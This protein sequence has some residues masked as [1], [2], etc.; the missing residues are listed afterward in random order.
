[1][2]TPYVA[3]S[4]PLTRGAFLQCAGAELAHPVLAAT[5]RQPVLNAESFRP[6]VDFFNRIDRE[7]VVNAIPNGSVWDWMKAN[8][9]RFACPDRDAEQIYY[10]RWW[11]FRKHIRET[12]LGFIITEF[13]KKVSHASEFNA[14][15]CALGHHVA[16][17]RW[18]HDRRY[19]E[20]DV[21]FWL[22][23]GEN[24]GLRRNFHQ[25]SG[26]AAASLYDRWL[27]D[28]DHDALTGY[29]DALL[30]DY[31]AWESER[32]TD[33]GLFWQRDVSDG[34]EE[35]ISGG[36]HV[37][38]LRPSINSYMY[39][40]ARAIAAIAGMAGKKAV[41]GEY[42]DK[43]ARIKE[44]VQR[45][46]WNP[47]LLFFDTIQ[48]SGEFAGVRENI[49]YTPW[50]FDLPSD[51]SG[52]EVAWRQLMDE[53]GFH[54]PFGPTT[55]ERRHP[56]FSIEYKTGDD[57]SWNGPSWPFATTITL[58]ALANTL[59]GYHQ[60]AT[61]KASWMETFQ[62]YTRSQHRRREDGSVIPWIDEN[63]DPLT[64]VWLARE[65]KSRKSGFYER[66]EFY[67]HSGYCDLVITGLAGLRPRA[68]NIVEVNPMIGEGEWEWFCLD[69]VPYHGRTLT[70]VW[71]QTGRKFGRG[72]GLTVFADGKRIAHAAG[73]GRVT[74]RL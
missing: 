5:E 49:G 55:S 42:L 12:P 29:L 37:R 34:M 18:L 25:F 65:R 45:K 60:S 17:G 3:G 24:G 9:P 6:Y 50:Y 16:E 7:E 62:I 35:S 57:C 36:R 39:G 74:G 19:V 73:L 53:G 31:G 20:Q 21:H 71:D 67:N 40:N 47:G 72:R 69:H 23:T 8:V 2:K 51:R 68:D 33:S 58:R 66:G 28:G 11:T 32:L 38:N 41:A 30:A 52:Y 4:I 26:W 56:K 63:L 44:R 59:N 43:A 64:G 48:E 70:I 1:M 54:A 13:L 10:F 22:R 61:S 15:S 46:L 27:V 14:L